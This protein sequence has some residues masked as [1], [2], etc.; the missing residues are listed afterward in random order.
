[1]YSEMEDRAFRYIAKHPTGRHY[2]GLNGGYGASA[3]SRI[4]L[5]MKPRISGN[6]CVA[7]PRDTPGIAAVCALPLPEMH[8]LHLCRYLRDT[9]LAAIFLT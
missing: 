1:M 6:G 8:R 2:N 5:H 7:Y 3:V 9:T 4:Y